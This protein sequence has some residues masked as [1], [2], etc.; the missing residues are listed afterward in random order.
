MILS[1]ILKY[2]LSFCNLTKTHVS[3]T[4]VYLIRKKLNNVI[5]K[6]EFKD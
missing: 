6:G 2:R 1:L 3:K 4:S 5:G